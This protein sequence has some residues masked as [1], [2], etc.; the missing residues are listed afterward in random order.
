MDAWVQDAFKTTAR[1]GVGKHTL[2][3]TRTIEFARDGEHLPTECGSDF[4]ESRPARCNEVARD[5]V[6]VENR[7]AESRKPLGRG[8]FAR[9]DAAGQRDGIR[10]VRDAHARPKSCRYSADSDSLYRNHTQPAA[11]M[12]GPNGIGVARS[13]PRIAR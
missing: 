4:G 11:A 9:G 7:H 10:A 6:G 8:T 5:Q 12:N 3:Q 1:I 2:A 13:W